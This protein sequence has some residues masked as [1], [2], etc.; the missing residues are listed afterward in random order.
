[1]LATC[2][3]ATPILMDEIYN[4]EKP[5]LFFKQEISKAL[6]EKRVLHTHQIGV[7]SYDNV[8]IN[9]YVN[10]NSSIIIPE[11]RRD[12]MFQEEGDGQ[13]ATV[14]GSENGK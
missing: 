3:V 11:Q 5:S 2:V 10:L 14:A 12:E 7:H 8:N 6:H 13:F 1:M 9:I 4:A